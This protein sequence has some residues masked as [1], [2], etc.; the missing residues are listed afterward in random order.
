MFL[1]ITKLKTQT[2]YSLLKNAIINKSITKKKATQH[3]KK[4]KKKVFL[5][6]VVIFYQGDYL[7]INFLLNILGRDRRRL[8]TPH[9][10]VVSIALKKKWAPQ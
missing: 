8:E 9:S 4:S 7:R 1:I 6:I 10:K 2:Y 5:L 3:N